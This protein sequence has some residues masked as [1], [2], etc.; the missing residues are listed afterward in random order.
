MMRIRSM[1]SLALVVAVGASLITGCGGAPEP[2]LEA[3]PSAGIVGAASLTEAPTTP[4]PN[5]PSPTEPAETLK[6]EPI[7]DLGRGLFVVDVRSG[8]ASRLP[9]SITSVR[10][11]G[12]YDVSPDGSRILFDNAGLAA[13]S[14]K[15]AERGLHQLYVANIDGS[16]VR[17]LTDDPIGASEGS[18][19]P[20]GTKVV[21]LGR[22][23]RLC[24]WRFPAD[25]T[26]LDLET[27]TTTVLAHGPA[28][29]FSEPFFGA[30][31][32]S[33]LFT[34]WHKQSRPD[35]WTIPAGGGRPEPLLEGR[36]LAHPSP[37][38]SSLVYQR[39][40]SWQ[41]GHCGIDYGVLW[42][43]DADGRDPRML[44]PKAADEL[45]GTGDPA[46]SPDGT[47][48]AFRANLVPPDGCAFNWKPGVYVMD[49]ATRDR[50]L[51]AVGR[52]I[53]WLDDRTLLI[54]RLG[55]GG[56]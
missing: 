8:T 26:V 22:R 39:I 11:A 32:N 45:R 48:L 30:D 43:S 29:H 35:L 12:N 4:A 19:S 41:E 38:G 49:V 17:Q 34:D 44:V 5:V 18:W 3:S 20:D 54:S 7:A 10:G 1:W 2:R 53:D 13:P 28:F 14:N 23:A 40:E 6:V 55:G 24:C 36:G 31:G 46:W 47:R 50:T 56:E 25:L 21:Y 15:P 33:I 52:S 16:H 27:G 51:I 9:R 42:I 37:D